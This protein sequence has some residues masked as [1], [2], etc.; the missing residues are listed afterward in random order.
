MAETVACEHCGK[1]AQKTATERVVVEDWVH[2]FCS[3]QCKLRWGEQAE[4]EEDE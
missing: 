1:V 2:Y 4:I 3:E